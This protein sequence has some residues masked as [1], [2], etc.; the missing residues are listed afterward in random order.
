MVLTFV[1]I[2]KKGVMRRKN[3]PHALKRLKIIFYLL[4]ISAVPLVYLYVFF[5]EKN[6]DIQT[7]LVY[8]ENLSSKDY[9]DDRNKKI[10]VNAMRHINERLSE[11]KLKKLGRKGKILKEYIS[12]KKPL[13]IMIFRPKKINLIFFSVLI[14][15]NSNHAICL[16]GMKKIR[17][18]QTHLD[19]IWM[20]NL[21]EKSILHEI[22][23]F[24]F[25]YLH[26]ITKTPYE[27]E[28]LLDYN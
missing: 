6:S 2:F 22:G 5:V 9:I 20:D 19:Y 1:V 11:T 14:P 12:G 4:L 24:F 15:S 18:L 7:I 13:K 3:K 26:P 23:H 27:F 8:K 28:D 21:L 16:P 17:I 25:P 10:L